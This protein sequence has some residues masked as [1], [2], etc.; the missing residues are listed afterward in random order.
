MSKAAKRR[1]MAEKLTQTIAQLL[2]EIADRRIHLAQAK[3]RATAKP[4][5]GKLIA[6]WFDAWSRHAPAIA[7]A[8][9]SL[10]RALSRL[11]IA[12]EKAAD[13]ET[14]E[15]EIDRQ[16]AA[17]RAR[18]VGLMRR[19][20]ALREGAAAVT[21]RWN[22]ERAEE[23]KRLKK[24][25]KKIEARTRKDLNARPD[26][27]KKPIA[28]PPPIEQP[29]DLGLA[30]DY[31]QP[32]PREGLIPGTYRVMDPEKLRFNLLDDEPLPANWTARHVGKRLIEA[33]DVLRRLPMNVRPQGYSALWPEYTHD[34]GELAIQ[35]G[36]ETLAIG[37]NAI[38]KTASTDEVARM[39]EALQ[40][41]IQYLSGCNAWSLSALNYWA[42]Q[43]DATPDDDTAPVDLLQF[44]AEALIAANEVVR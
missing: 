39:N 43:R 11:P 15:R 41:I 36:A 2:K 20:D 33:H 44:V 3:A 42:S 16:R 28:L 19:L 24:L 34:A 12:N 17:I 14:Q 8:E 29:A 4:H 10:R 37:R 22:A 7:K 9:G 30:V 1:A 21:K 35:A 13:A 18:N 27:M 25:K 32:P 38:I 6:G 23:E 31:P 5:K 40:W 26:W